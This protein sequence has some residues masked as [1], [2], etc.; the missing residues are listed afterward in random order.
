MAL[1]K[2]SKT[3]EKVVRFS[4]PDVE[5]QARARLAR[6]EAQADE[7]IAQAN[8]RAGEI[9]SAAREEGQAA[10]WQQGHSDG[11]DCGANAALD[12][13]RQKLAELI[14]TFNAATAALDE[15]RAQV[16]AA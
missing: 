14:A 6:A 7:I 4:L 2:S 5:E 3:P 16:E 8:A 15:F 1:I 11:H 13:Y 9:E 12:Q 10:G